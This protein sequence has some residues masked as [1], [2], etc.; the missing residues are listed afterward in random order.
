MPTSRALGVLLDGIVDYA[1]LF[2]PAAL[3]MDRAVAEYAEAR[4]G[5]SAWMLGR[6]VLPAE[7][8]E[9]FRQSLV[10]VDDRRSD[11]WSLSAI[12]SGRPLEALA[13]VEDFNRHQAVSGHGAAASVDALE[14]KIDGL[15]ALD[16]LAPALPRKVEVFV[17]V[18]ATTDGASL[19][20][21]IS[22]IAALGLR[23]KLRTGGITASA[24]PSAALVARFMI[25]CQRFGVPFKATAGLHHPV[26]GD[27]RLTYQASSASARM[28][29][30]LNVAL[31]SAAVREGMVHADLVRLL[32]DPA[33]EA[34]AFTD[35]AAAWR[36]TPISLDALIAARQTGLRG[37]GSCSFREPVADLTTLRLLDHQ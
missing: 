3:D 35:D 20:G 22:R 28:F 23:A 10:G 21:L 12:V 9:T 2:P 13:Q 30:F 34:F 24:F 32:E 4:T 15:E 37:F 16:S 8:L 6:F 1:G 7:R 17:E 11:V 31:A 36:G 25:A 29:G 5:Q 27:Y 19:E 26:C 18:P 33:P 14:I